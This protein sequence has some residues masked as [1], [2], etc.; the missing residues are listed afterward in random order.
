MRLTWARWEHGDQ[1]TV[2]DKNRAKDGKQVEWDSQR[3]LASLL[4]KST[5]VEKCYLLSHS[6]IEAK[7][8]CP[9]SYV[10]CKLD[11][12]FFLSVVLQGILS[13]A[14]WESHIKDP[15]L[16]HFCNKASSPEGESSC[17][18]WCPFLWLSLASADVALPVTI[19]PMWQAICTRWVEERKR[20]DPTV[21][22][23]NI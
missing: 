9:P 16:S 2:L 19:T 14:A 11:C 7:Y 3:N 20:A 10:S 23:V 12:H 21:L 6:F 13:W 4:R 17:Y 8:S 15:L 5:K 1:S 22:L 18:C